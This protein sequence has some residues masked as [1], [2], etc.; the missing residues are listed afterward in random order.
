MYFLVELYSF[1]MQFLYI[2]ILVSYIGVLYYRSWD[3][4]GRTFTIHH[5]SVCTQP[6]GEEF[7]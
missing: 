2:K 6:L 7:R 3:H 1:K 5:G 4:K